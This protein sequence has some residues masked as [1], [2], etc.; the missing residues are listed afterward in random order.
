MIEL[1]ERDKLEA[2]LHAILHIMKAQGDV[3]RRLLSTVFLHH[4]KEH[5]DRCEVQDA[6]IHYGFIKMFD[7]VE[8]NYF[9]LYKKMLV[10]NTR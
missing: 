6:A 7:F 8:S 10:C 5:Y 1:T 2:R 4:S 9:D 3:R